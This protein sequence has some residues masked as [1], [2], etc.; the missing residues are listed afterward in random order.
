M[1]LQLL[2][3]VSYFLSILFIAFLCFSL[4]WKMIKESWQKAETKTLLKKLEN[5]ITKAEQKGETKAVK[6]QLKK[7]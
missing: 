4:D 3:Y 1:Y 7:V 2:N 5:K 6:N